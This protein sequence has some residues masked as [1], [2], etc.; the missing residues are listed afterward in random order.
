MIYQ[1]YEDLSAFEKDLGED[2][3]WMA[4]VIDGYKQG[5]LFQLLKIFEQGRRSYGVMQKDDH[6]QVRRGFQ[7]SLVRV[8]ERR[9]FERLQMLGLQK[10][11]AIVQE[12]LQVD[13]NLA[14]LAAKRW[15]GS[16]SPSKEQ[17]RGQ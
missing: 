11:E 3:A 10:S 6:L 16:N 5:G 1:A 9:V 2:Y 17:Q 12:A 15:S 4:D 7:E 14:F 8:N 13:K